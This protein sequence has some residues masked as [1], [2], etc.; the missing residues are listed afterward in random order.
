MNDKKYYFF[1]DVHL[2]LKS[3]EIE[4]QK[5]RKL[6]D[7]LQHISHD[8]EK[9]FILGDLFDCWI[10]YRKVVPK[11][12]FRLLARLN[13]MYEAG[14]E[15]N[16]LSGNH[17]FWLNT[18]LR[19]EVGLKIHYDNLIVELEG[20]KFFMTHGDGLA[21]KDVG[22]KIIKKILRNKFN[23]F[24]YSL[25]HPDVGIS[26]AQMSSRQSRNYTD[27]KQFGSGDSMKEFAKAKISDGY[28]YVIMGHRHKPQCIP[29]AQGYFV[30]LGDWIKHDTYGEFSAGNFELKKW[31]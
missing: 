7:F 3:K 28:D 25:I 21:K 20:K 13:E 1:S 8:A 19:D 31:K 6:I 30:T 17:D 11:G 12:Y 16:F 22:Y 27:E 9:V 24:L 18:Y 2:G 14:I 10:E 4:R 26:L 23:Q 29:I 15:L 5:E